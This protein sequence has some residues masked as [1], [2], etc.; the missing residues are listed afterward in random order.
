MYRPRKTSGPTNRSGR[1]ELPRRPQKVRQL[2]V[3]RRVR[4]AERT[5]QT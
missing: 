2:T 3:V 4:G 5:L 1:R